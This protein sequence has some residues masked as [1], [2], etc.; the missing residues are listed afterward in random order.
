[1][2]GDL[3]LAHRDVPELMPYLHLPV[4]S[5]SDRI[6]KAMNRKHTVADYL[7]VIDR[8]RAVRPDMAMSGDFIVGFPGETDADF[9][10]TLQLVERVD[11]ASAY[12][13]KYSPRPGTP[14]AD[15][16]DQVP[17]DVKSE[18]LHRLQDLL[19]AQQ[20]GFNAR[21]VGRRL[22]VLL[23]RPGRHAGQM[24]G[25]SPYMQAVVVEAP[26]DAAGRMVE[27]DIDTV[28]S[29]S[30]N[31]RIAGGEWSPQ[32]LYPASPAVAATPVAGSGL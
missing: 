19:S 7:K 11:Y 28:N 24:V 23:E 30:L 1:M 25:R 29:F 3:I 22:P 13:F 31:G 15:L 26:A 6:L 16:G 14:A 20:R 2:G 32:P 5:G 12:S 8:L 18:R 21:M 9:E 27:V 4:Q 17:E 10:A